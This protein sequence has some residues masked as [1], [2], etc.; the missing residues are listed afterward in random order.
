MGR[1]VNSNTLCSVKQRHLQAFTVTFERYT[2]ANLL[3][4][5]VLIVSIVLNR[6]R[7]YKFCTTVQ[8]FIFDVL[9][10]EHEN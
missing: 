5:Y 6:W 1:L 8:N 10:R 3:S 2:Q 7:C 9:Y 4:Y